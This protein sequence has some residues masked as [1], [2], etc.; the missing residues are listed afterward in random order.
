MTE[1]LPKED[2]YENNVES[3]DA[4]KSGLGCGTL[5]NGYEYKVLHFIRAVYNNKNHLI[6]HPDIKESTI[7]SSIY[8]WFLVLG[9][10]KEEC[11]D[12]ELIQ[13]STTPDP[14]QHMGK[15]QKHKK[16]HTQ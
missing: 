8:P 5:I 10:S 14:R 9:Q 3:L 13:S 16:H 6:P 15:L 7:T 12:Q 2:F 4:E 11:E 1:C